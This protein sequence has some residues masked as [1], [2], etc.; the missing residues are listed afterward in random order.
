MHVIGL[1]RLRELAFCSP[2]DDVVLQAIARRLV[3]QRHAAGSTVFAQ[4]DDTHDVYLVLSGHLRVTSYSKNGREWVMHDLHPGDIVGELAAIDGGPRSSTLVAV[5]DA[6]LGRLEPGAFRTLMEEHPAFAMAVT[7][8]L[9]E[10]LR[11]LQLRMQLWMA[12]VPTRICAELLRLASF[13]RVGDNSARLAPAPRHLDIANR[14][15]THREA[16][17]RTISE[18]QRLKV[19]R[20]DQDALL[21]LDLGMLSKLAEGM[22]LAVPAK[23]SLAAR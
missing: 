14:V 7:I 1:E 20:R 9:V 2:F 21:V 17:S 16:V 19:L 11:K 23:R 10:L 8:Q 15:N 5:T 18:L 22:P 4:N 12:P 3:L 13:N 6:Q